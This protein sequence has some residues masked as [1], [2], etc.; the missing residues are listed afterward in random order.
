MKF[1]AALGALCAALVLVGVFAPSAAPRDEAATVLI[2]DG[3]GE[4]KD[5]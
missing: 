2:Q 1:Y 4:C 3:N 5:C